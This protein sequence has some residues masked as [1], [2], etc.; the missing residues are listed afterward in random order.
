MSEA[1]IYTLQLER[2]IYE[3]LKRQDVAAARRFIYEKY[4]K[5][6]FSKLTN[7]EMI[8]AIPQLRKL[9]AKKD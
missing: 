3:I 1:R 4:G 9:Y 6:L 2:D 5:L 7:D 8:D